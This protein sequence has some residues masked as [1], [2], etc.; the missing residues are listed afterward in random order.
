MSEILTGPGLE[1]PAADFRV[2]RVA[3]TEQLHQMAGVRQSDTPGRGELAPRAG[4][5][6]EC[7][8]PHDE[9]RLPGGSLQHAFN[10]RGQGEATTRA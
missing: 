10:P 8:D 7:A 2:D 1:D 9:F 6:Q 5:G 4:P 3:G